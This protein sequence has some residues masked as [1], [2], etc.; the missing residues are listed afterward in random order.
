[1]QL[2]NKLLILLITII[3]LIILFSTSVF[4][5]EEENFD[6]TNKEDYE[7]YILFQ[8]Q[9]IDF[10]TLNYKAF[11]YDSSTDYYYF[12]VSDADFTIRDKTENDI[13]NL[14]SYNSSIVLEL[15]ENNTV[16]YDFKLKSDCIYIDDEE[17]FIN[18]SNKY[19]ASSS[20]VNLIRR[21]NNGLI[22]IPIYTTE[23]AYN[24]DYSKI[25]TADF[26]F[27]GN[28][29]FYNPSQET[30]LAPIVA[31][32]EMEKTLAQVVTILPI[33]L[34]AIVTIISVMKAIKFLK[35]LLT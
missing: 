9:D 19:S 16:L 32:V 20:D 21:E 7:I 6:F 10:T 17:K 13:L 11:L 5:A 23:F 15:S 4:A 28:A 35:K 24:P 27:V 18:I 29:V 3:S 34:I 31:G 30:L 14:Q 2:K 33:I 1:M 26:Q 25:S 8:Y 12:F 22:E